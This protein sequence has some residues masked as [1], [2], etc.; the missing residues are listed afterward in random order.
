MLVLHKIEFIRSTNKIHTFKGQTK[1][2][3]APNKS[4]T[5]TITFCMD[6]VQNLLWRNH[7]AFEVYN[8]FL[9]KRTSILM[10]PNM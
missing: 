2:T 9:W 7:E 8:A 6:Y 4:E 3:F 5:V 1:V 10:F